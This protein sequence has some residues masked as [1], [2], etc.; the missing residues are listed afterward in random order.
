MKRYFILWFAI[1]AVV[2]LAGSAFGISWSEREA[3]A[4][5]RPVPDTGDV[6]LG[7]Y[8]WLRYDS[9]PACTELVTHWTITQTVGGISEVLVDEVRPPRKSCVGLSAVS[10]FSS[11]VTPVP[12]AQ[13]DAT[14]VAEDRRNNLYY[15]RTFHYIV[16]L[17]LPTGIVL[18]TADGEILDLSALRDA[19]IEQMADLYDLLTGAFSQTASGATV[20]NFVASHGGSAEAFPVW[21][22]VVAAS[23]P[24]LSFGGLNLPIIAPPNVKLAYDRFL[25]IYVVPS[26]GALDGVLAQLAE[27]ETEFL[28]QVLVYAGTPATGEPATVYLHDAAW[29]ILEMAKEEYER[30]NPVE[31]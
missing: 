8:L 29:E 24:E 1:G 16:P 18:K 25:F 19:E 4:S 10:T 12:G 5:L 23:E 17:S 28:G 20:D 27:Y 31:E 9:P 15:E 6:V 30:R 7:F 13:Y 3:G 22:F 11:L 2:L 21:V 14:I 26:S